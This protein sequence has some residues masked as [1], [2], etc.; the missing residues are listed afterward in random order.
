MAHSL[1]TVLLGNEDLRVGQSLTVVWM[2]LGL[3]LFVLC[4]SVTLDTYVSRFRSRCSA[5]LH[6]A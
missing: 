5:R 6:G 2:G 4:A 3:N 1:C